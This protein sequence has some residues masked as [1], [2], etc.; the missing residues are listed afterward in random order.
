MIGRVR[1]SM[2]QI[3]RKINILFTAEK[4]RVGNAAFGRCWA[5]IGDRGGLDT[6]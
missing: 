5:F 1:L 6:F 2:S 4:I 3:L